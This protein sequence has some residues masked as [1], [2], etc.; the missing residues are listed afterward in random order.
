[1]AG[2]VK[3]LKD[4]EVGEKLE[5]RSRIVT[6]TD[7]DIFL[8]ITGMRG[9]AFLSDEAARAMGLKARV[10]P[11]AMTLGILFGLLG[12]V[13]EGALFT[14]LN[15]LKLLAPVYPLDKLSAECEVL[16]KKET[17]K[18]DRVFVT[19]LWTLKNQSGMVVAQ[20]E[21]T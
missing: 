1:M 18:G 14:N 19:Y 5:G 11:G 12:D 2:K 8:D 21:N 7:L 4:A 17:S 9:D 20:G 16:G 10:C 13:L 15:N 6:G 3:L